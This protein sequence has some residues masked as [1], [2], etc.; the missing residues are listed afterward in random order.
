[1]KTEDFWNGYWSDGYELVANL[2]RTQADGHSRALIVM[3][4]QVTRTIYWSYDSAS[5]FEG[6]FDKLHPNGLER[7]DGNINSDFRISASCCGHKATTTHK[8]IED[9]QAI[10][11]GKVTKDCTQDS[12][13][14]IK[15]ILSDKANL[16]TA[17]VAAQEE[18]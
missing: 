3:R 12:T 15:E 18:S 4:G 1:V 6:L 9:V 16:T 11:D 7:L 10:L 5:S 14:L 2:F 13:R 8:F 17:G